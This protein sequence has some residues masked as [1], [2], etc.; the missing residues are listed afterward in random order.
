M[1]SLQ[2]AEQKR[3]ETEMQKR[4]ERIETWRTERKKETVPTQFVITPPSKMWSLE[5]DE[6]E[7][8]EGGMGAGHEGDV[9]PLD[10]YMMVGGSTGSIHPAVSHP[11][12]VILCQSSCVGHPVSVI[13]CQSSCVSHPVS[14]ILCQS[15]CVSHPVSV[16]LCRSSCVS[17]PVSVIL[18]QSS[19]VSH[20]VSV[21]LCQ[22]SCVSHS[23]IPQIYCHIK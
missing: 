15:S 18:C 12:S 7:D 10:A 4:R 14:V 5:D 6:D 17:H 21:I 11:V 1:L 16:I 2:E 8:E 19:C 20:P 22:S 9:D 23:I 13:L 3:L